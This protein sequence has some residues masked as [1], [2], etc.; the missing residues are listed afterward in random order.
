MKR[1][2]T[3]TWTRLQKFCSFVALCLTMTWISGCMAMTGKNRNKELMSREQ[4]SCGEKMPPR[5]P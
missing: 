5:I 3:R 4:F 1:L 2:Q